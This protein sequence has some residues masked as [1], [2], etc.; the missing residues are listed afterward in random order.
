MYAWAVVSYLTCCNDCMQRVF[1]DC[2]YLDGMTLV[3]SLRA[4][5]RIEDHTEAWCIVYKWLLTHSMLD[6]I[7]NLLMLRVICNLKVICS[8]KDWRNDH[9]HVW[10]NNL[11][12]HCVCWV[13]E[14]R[15]TNL[16]CCRSTKLCLE[17]FR[18]HAEMDVHYWVT[19][20]RGLNSVNM[21][22]NERQCRCFLPSLG[23]E[24]K[25][26]LTQ[27]LINNLIVSTSY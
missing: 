1:A 15:H 12:W 9:V 2:W 19:S 17:L 8:A 23:I 3:E 20:I 10:I 25:V 4:F 27:D 18:I 11:F 26:H 6:L 21:F 5:N 16:R 22:Q 14:S 7:L 13:I 24:I